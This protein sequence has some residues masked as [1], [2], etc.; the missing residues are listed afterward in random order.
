MKRK[1][2]L[3]NAASAAIQT[4]TSALLLFFLYR[5]LL[6]QLGAERLGIWAVVLASV[7]IGR[8]TDMGFAGTAL[9]FV[10]SALGE[11]NRQ[12]AAY[13]LQTAAFS[14]AAALGI[15]LIIVLPMIE[16]I[17]HW[18]LPE[19]ALTE[20]KG[21]LPIAL[22]SLLLTMISGVFQ[23]GIDACHRM[24]IKN[25]L[26]ITGNL[27]MI[28]LALWLV[29]EHAL[30]G[31]AIAQCIQAGAMLLGSWLILRRLLPELP[32]VPSHWRYVEFRE[33][34]GYATNFQVGMVAGLLF[35]PLTKI[36][37]ARFGDLT[38]TAYFDMANQL[39]QKARAVI[40]SAQ[41]SLVPEIASIRKENQADREKLF[42]QAYGIS[43]L[44]VVP[45]FLGIA[46]MLPFISWIW[47][48]HYQDSFVTFGILMSAG[49]L[50]ASVG[51]VSYF[52]NL[53]TADLFWNTV[54]HVST[55]VLNLS[56]SWLLGQFLPDIG[57]VLGATL[58]LVIPNFLLN[59]L[60]FKRL[61]IR[62][63]D[64]VPRGHRI[65]CTAI[66]SAA[67]ALAF[68]GNQFGWFTAG[69]SGSLLPG[70]AFA[71]FLPIALIADPQGRSLFSRLSLRNKEH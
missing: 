47:I 18:A 62:L 66:V 4:I 16:I 41:Q 56:L 68:A 25:V 19:S 43:F 42:V 58:A 27:L 5:Y 29:P 33:M 12:R 36:L 23:S 20:A 40:A 7:S 28:V 39:V 24:Y 9:K 6:Q 63:S 69:V 26:L 30:L 10:A 53:G 37:L 65:Y 60:V 22:I 8:L 2:L 54:N 48:G 55:G 51:A 11:G 67:C 15:V 35:E 45:Y 34:V 17:L 50:V 32:P 57:V 13:L 14:I 70:L 49:W 44:I 61:G 52:Y 31:I 71:C 3:G 21:I 1:R 46:L 59:A 64:T 38:L